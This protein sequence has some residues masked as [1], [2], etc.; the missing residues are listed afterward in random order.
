MNDRQGVDKKFRSE[1]LFT[2]LFEGFSMYPFLKP[3][4]RLVMK[5]DRP[6]SINVGDIVLFENDQPGLSR[7][8]I[9]HR[10]I[11]IISK[12]G[13]LTKGDNLPRPDPEL[14]SWDQILGQ[15][16]LVLRGER[17]IPLTKG[18]SGFLGKW[19]AFLSRRNLTPG[20]LA[21]KAKHLVGMSR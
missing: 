4:D 16:V 10:V 8:L 20:I 13:Y 14:K 19:I 18:P 6:S 3:G 15:V 12:G 1:D 17:L 5:K 21:V 11:R 9:A 7:G 2:I